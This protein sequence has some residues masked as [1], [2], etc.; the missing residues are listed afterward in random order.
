HR[1]DVGFPQSLID[2]P[3]WHRPFQLTD[4]DGAVQVAMTAVLLESPEHPSI[5][6][7][8]LRLLKLH[9]R[10]SG[11]HRRAR[12]FGAETGCPQCAKQEDSAAVDCDSPPE[13]AIRSHR[14]TAG[15]Y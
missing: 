1:D 15:D 13:R 5:S 11:G 7:S 9:R 12:R 2:D 4:V 3:A 6:G 10:G 14:L 8:P